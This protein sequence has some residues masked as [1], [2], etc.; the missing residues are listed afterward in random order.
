MGSAAAAKLGSP[1][2]PRGG[3]SQAW[4]KEA[5][6]DP[7]PAAARLREGGLP[8]VRRGVGRWG[9]GP[10]DGAPCRALAATA[11]GVSAPTPCPQ[12][13][14]CGS[15]ERPQQKANQPA[16]QPPPAFNGRSSF[17]VEAI[18]AGSEPLSSNLFVESGP[19]LQQ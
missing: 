14:A 18:E 16:L 12:L 9:V 5:R 17:H 8:G 4:R 7:P 15:P 6:P 2:A 10:R 11:G 3:S 13:P 1:G 19:H